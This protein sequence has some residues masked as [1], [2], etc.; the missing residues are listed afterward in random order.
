[1]CRLKTPSRRKGSPH[2]LLLASSLG[3]GHNELLL[4]GSHQLVRTRGS[5]GFQELGTIREAV[6]DADGTKRGEE[7]RTH[8][9]NG[10][11]VEEP[12]DDL[13]DSRADVPSDRKPSGPP[14]F[15]HL[16]SFS[17]SPTTC[18]LSLLPLKSSAPSCCSYLFL[19]FQPLAPSCLSVN[20]SPI[21]RTL[22]FVVLMATGGSW[23]VRAE[24]NE[25]VPESELDWNRSLKSPR[26][27]LRHSA[28][29]E[30]GGGLVLCSAIR[31]EL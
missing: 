5:S 16:P 22:C 18:S 15:V 6:K 11:D 14:H 17:T 3:K 2:L 24:S 13:S 20:Y 19:P 28:V 25:T 8:M 1:M 12:A 31:C 4:E 27:E 7:P 10:R 29:G 21:C 23:L 9:P 26:R 30:N